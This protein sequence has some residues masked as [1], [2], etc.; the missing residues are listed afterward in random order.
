MAAALAA[1]AL[2]A[3]CGGVLGSAG[4]GADGRGADD[5]GAAGGGVAA[6]ADVSVG[7]G[8]AGAGDPEAVVPES[9][10]GTYSAESLPERDGM[11]YVV[12]Q[13]LYGD[14]RGATEMTAEELLGTEFLASSGAS[15]EGVASIDGSVAECLL[16]SEGSGVGEL[17]AQVHLVPAAFGSTSLLIEVDADGDFPLGVA[18]APQGIGSPGVSDLGDVTLDLVEGAAITAVM[19]AD[20]PDGDVPAGLEADCELLD[21][22]EHAVCEITGT[23]DEGGDGT[24]YGTAQPG[25]GGAKRG[26]VYVFTQ[27]PA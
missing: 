23:P 8:P 5:R 22:G 25:Y 13:N 14:Q 1:G 21:G 20:A 10:S 3:G 15:C 4:T 11:R 12:L 9:W 26:Q 16:A 2:L 7:V 27:M 24:W 19:M 6:P 18:E 17:A